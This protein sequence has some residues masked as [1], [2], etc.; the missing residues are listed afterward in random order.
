MAT[1]PRGDTRTKDTKECIG[2]DKQSR[3]EN[4]SWRQELEKMLDQKIQQLQDHTEKQ[5]EDNKDWKQNLENNTLKL[6]N[7]NKVDSRVSELQYKDKI[8]LWRQNLE[9]RIQELKEQE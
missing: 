7:Q 2:H 6:I 1:W 9:Q 3:E 8:K 4:E 5:R